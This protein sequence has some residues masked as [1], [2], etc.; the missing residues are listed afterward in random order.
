ML[1]WSGIGLPSLSVP[2]HGALRQR[3]EQG[4]ATVSAGIW[5]DAHAFICG[6]AAAGGYAFIILGMRLV[7]LLRMS[8]RMVRRLM[9]RLGLCLGLRLMVGGCVRPRGLGMGLCVQFLLCWRLGAGL[10]WGLPLG[11]PIRLHML[12]GVRLCL[13]LPVGLLLGTGLRLGLRLL[14]LSVG[15]TW[16][17][18]LPL[19]L[20][21]ELGTWMGPSPN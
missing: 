12:R 10:G 3:Q 7:R 15:P 20:R 11:L 5:T 21:Q 4:C 18:G 13:Q 14:A 17:F 1:Q 8:L 6:S 16:G 2:S 9:M 19:R